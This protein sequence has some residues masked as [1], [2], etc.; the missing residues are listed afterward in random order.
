VWTT[1]YWKRNWKDN[2]VIEGSLGYSFNTDP[3]NLK[4]PRPF[5]ERDA[6]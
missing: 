5:S 2:D 1:Y 6:A 3:T 4:E